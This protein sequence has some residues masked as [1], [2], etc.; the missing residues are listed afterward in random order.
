MLCRQTNKKKSKIN[1]KFVTIK[2]KVQIA[3]GKRC[4]TAY[5]M[6]ILHCNDHY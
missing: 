4:Y 3:K 1:R 2:Y 6:K 5:F